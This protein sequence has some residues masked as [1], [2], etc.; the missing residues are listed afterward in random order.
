MS[1]HDSVRPLLAVSAAGLL[2]AAEERLVREHARDCA[3]C[4][5][6]LAALGELAAALAIL[7][8]P[9]PPPDLLART[10]ARIAADRDRREAQRLAVISALCAVTVCA[11]LCVLL[12]PYLGPMIW[13]T[14][15]AIPT[16]PAAAAA[17]LLTTRSARWAGREAYPTGRSL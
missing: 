4:A 1:Q 10:Q 13:V 16:I 5:A 2:D 15:T 17:F 14:A 12:Q 11:A 6:E 8:A 9:A 3:D 7:P